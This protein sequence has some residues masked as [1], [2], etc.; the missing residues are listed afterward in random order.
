MRTKVFRTLRSLLLSIFVLLSLHLASY[1][2]FNEFSRK[3]EKKPLKRYKGAIKTTYIPK[4]IKYKT[5]LIKTAVLWH[6]PKFKLLAK[7]LAPQEEALRELKALEILFEGVQKNFPQVKK[8]YETSSKNESIIHTL[9]KEV[10]NQVNNISLNIDL[11]KFNK[12]KPKEDAYEIV[13]KTK[14]YLKSN[15]RL[16]KQSLFKHQSRDEKVN[17]QTREAYNNLL[18]TSGEAALKQVEKLYLGDLKNV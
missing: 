14:Q 11:S 3:L 2:N 4:Q 9:G 6:A 16:Y 8:A 12:V 15:F 18:V 5:K 10:L 1:A 13:S 17:R 7:Q